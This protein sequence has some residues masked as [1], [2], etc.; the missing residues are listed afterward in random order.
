MSP[1]ILDEQKQLK[2]AGFDPGALDGVDGKCTQAA[3]DARD[4]IANAAHY[5]PDSRSAA[6][7]APLLPEVRPV[8][9]R[10]LQALAGLGIAAKIVSGTRTYAEQD[11]LYE[12]GRTE[13][14]DIVT[15]ARGG[16]SNHN[17]G[18]AFDIGIFEDGRYLEDSRL[19]A[20]AGAIGK[21]LRLDW[22][23]DWNSIQDEPHFELRPKWAEPLSESQMLA[24]FRAR[25][26]SGKNLFA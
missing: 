5:V 15:N 13:P 2:A 16:H 9:A 3:R 12:K 6:N 14:G 21:A 19:Y 11:A 24:E 23:G 10:L 26:A 22:G 4:G 18:V 8:A 20:H 17:F 1:A 25:V 7:I